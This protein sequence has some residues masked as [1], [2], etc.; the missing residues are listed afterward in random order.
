MKHV[1]WLLLAVVLVALFVVRGLSGTAT[2]EQRER[3]E[4]AEAAILTLRDDRDAYRAQADSLARLDSI[5]AASYTADSLKWETDRSDAREAA[6]VE[7]QTH[8]DLA[9]RIRAVSDS[10]VVTLVD[11][12]EASHSAV[13]AQQ[14]RIIVSL[15]AERAALWTQRET[16]GELVASL[17]SERGA[18]LAIIAEQ[19][20]AIEAWR[21]VANPS[22]TQRIVNAIP[23]VGGGAVVAVIAIVALRGN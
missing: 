5:R 20:V 22:W 7:E 17:E 18:N 16:L 10:S 21:S 2:A 14:A 13:V 9:D 15:T 8:T 3:A 23:K 12:L 4:S 1:P 6:A 19:A 11:S